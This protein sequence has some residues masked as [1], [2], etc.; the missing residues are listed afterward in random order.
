[1]QSKG[2][3]VKVTVDASEPSSFQRFVGVP[4]QVWLGGIAATSGGPHTV[5]LHAT[6]R[7]FIDHYVVGGKASAGQASASKG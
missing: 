1:V 3:T 5:Q 4:R 2:G 7:R 6:C